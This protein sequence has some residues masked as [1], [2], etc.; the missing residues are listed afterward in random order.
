MKHRFFLRRTILAMGVLLLI[1]AGIPRTDSATG[2]S[3]ARERLV[4]LF[5]HDL[6]SYFLPQRVAVPGGPSGRLA[7]RRADT[8]SS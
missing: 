5:T 2:G 6:H 7:E 8:Q 4:I 1:L 3:S